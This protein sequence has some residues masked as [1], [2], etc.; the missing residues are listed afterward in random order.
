[1]R[2]I[3]AGSRD[4]NNYGLAEKECHRI[5]SQLAD[6]GYIPSDVNESLPFIEIVS[7]HAIGADTLGERF[8]QDYKICVK[9]ILPNWELFGKNAGYIRNAEMAS[10]AKRDAD[11]GVLIAFHKNNSR[12]TK[13]MI[14]IGH[15]HGLRVFVINVEEDV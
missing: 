1:M 2:V 6:E 4:F 11:L 10:Y 15:E 13:Q 12:G 3:I 14:E 5:F 9:Y 8:A 7:G